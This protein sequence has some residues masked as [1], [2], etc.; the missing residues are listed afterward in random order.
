MIL[1]VNGKAETFE[2][3]STL[4]ELIAF[5]KL[6][7]ANIVVEHNLLIIPAEKWPGTRLRENDTIEIVSFVGGG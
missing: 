5:K 3:P 1:K 6:C 7:P 2:R 4:E